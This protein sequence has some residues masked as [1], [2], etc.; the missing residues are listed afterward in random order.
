MKQRRYTLAQIKYRARERAARLRTQAQ[1]LGAFLRGG[2]KPIRLYTA[3]REDRGDPD[4]LRW[5]YMGRIDGPASHPDAVGSTEQRGWTDL[6]YS[7]SD[8]EHTQIKIEEAA[9]R[10]WGPWVYYPEADKARAK[11]EAFNAEIR[12][13]RYQ[14]ERRDALAKAK[15]GA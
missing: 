12:M 11:L 1:G 8:S 13:K 6:L 14:R 15:G 5:D 7:A 2:C 3:S 4:C 10:L 9:R